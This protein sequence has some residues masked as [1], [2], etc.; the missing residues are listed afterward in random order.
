[1]CVIEREAGV[2]VKTQGVEVVEV[3]EFKYTGSTIQS[4][5]Q[6]AREV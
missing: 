2:A 1:M 5:R 3:D 4:N 6:R